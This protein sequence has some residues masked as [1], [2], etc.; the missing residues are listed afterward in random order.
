MRVAEASGT[1]NLALEAL[2]GRSFFAFGEGMALAHAHN[3]RVSRWCAVSFPQ[4]ARRLSS[5]LATKGCTPTVRNNEV[6]CIQT[7]L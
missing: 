4:S 6:C 3:R 1:W 5:K 7:S 2:D